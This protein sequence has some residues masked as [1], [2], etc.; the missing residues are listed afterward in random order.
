MGK[1][2]LNLPGADGRYST[3]AGHHYCSWAARHFWEASILRRDKDKAYCQGQEKRIL[4][5]SI[6]LAPDPAVEYGM[7]KTM[8]W[9]LA[10]LSFN[11]CLSLVAIHMFIKHFLLSNRAFA[12][13]I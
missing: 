10:C 5:K 7:L 1:K 8:P 2:Y 11:A 9:R 6:Q 13:N 12:Q 3:Y 4:K